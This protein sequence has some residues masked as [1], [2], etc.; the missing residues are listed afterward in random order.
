MTITLMIL[1]RKV[2]TEIFLLREK[3]VRLT[4]T[5]KKLKVLGL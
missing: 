3:T 5:V 4:S 2:N 1:I